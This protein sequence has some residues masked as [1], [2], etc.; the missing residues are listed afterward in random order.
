M[1]RYLSSASSPIICFYSIAKLAW[2]TLLFLA[3]FM[4]TQTGTPDKTVEPCAS[5]EA[6]VVVETVANYSEGEKVGIANGDV[7]RAWTRGDVKGKI[8]S[9]FDL[10]EVELEQQPRGQVTLEGTRGES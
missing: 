3:S 9:P 5:E 8:R 1:I 6:G 2:F 7:I 10:I 4:N